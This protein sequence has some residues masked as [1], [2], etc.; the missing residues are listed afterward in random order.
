[1]L[2]FAAQFDFE[3]FNAPF[4][5]GFVRIEEY[6]EAFATYD[7]APVEDFYGLA[8]IVAGNNHFC[9][10]GVHFVGGNKDVFA[11]YLVAVSGF[12]IGEFAATSSA[13]TVCSDT[14]RYC[15]PLAGGFCD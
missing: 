5:G 10:E 9:S 6:V 14:H 15:F 3:I 12:T 4:S 2:L 11:S 1:M 7:P 8:I 13:G